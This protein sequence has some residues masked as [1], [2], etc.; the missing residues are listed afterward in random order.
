MK[1]ATGARSATMATSKLLFWAALAHC[2]RGD[3]LTAPA[4][5]PATTPAAKLRAILARDGCVAMPCCYDG[6]SARLVEAQGFDV[7]FMSGFSVAAS[8]GYPDA[9]LVSAGE[10]QDSARVVASALRGGTP[11]IADGDTGYGNAVNAHRTV[12]GLA[13]VGMAGVMIEDQVAPKRCG[14]TKVKAVVG[15]LAGDDGRRT[16]TVARMT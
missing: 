11:C 9:G 7:T 12:R 15:P 1:A 2:G 8:R 3:A 14:H 4:A 5:A 16:Q 10:M 13:Q 6:I